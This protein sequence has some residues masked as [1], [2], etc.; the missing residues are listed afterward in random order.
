MIL[1]IRFARS[2]IASSLALAGTGG[3]TRAQC[4][5]FSTK[6]RNTPITAQSALFNAS[7]DAT[8]ATA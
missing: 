1:K 8:P 2:L 5:I 7:F 3:E 6:W 4:R